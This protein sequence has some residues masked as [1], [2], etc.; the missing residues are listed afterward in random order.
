MPPDDKPNAPMTPREYVEQLVLPTLHEFLCARDDRRRAYLACLVVCHVA[1]SLGL[2]EAAREPG[3]AELSTSARK[4][5]TDAATKTAQ[6]VALERCGSTFTLVQDMANGT[7]H[8]ARLPLLP[9]CEV[10]VPPF[11]FGIAGPGF[12]L[13]RIGTPGLAVRIDDKRALLDACVQQVLA[14]FMCAYPQHLGGIA[15]AF[16]DPGL[17]VLGLDMRLEW[18]LNI[19][20]WA[21]GRIELAEV[22]L[23]GSRADGTSHPD[24]DVDLGVVLAA[25]NA[26]EPGAPCR[27]WAHESWLASQ[28]V[29]LGQLRPGVGGRLRVE[30]FSRPDEPR[31]GAE[32]AA[33]S[34]AILLWTRAYMTDA[35]LTSLSTR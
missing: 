31:G 11:S 26:S 23:F 16:M 8:P 19:S 15:L 3:F 33:R 20:T 14:A 1:D 25:P 30:V 35:K 13:G 28:G 32:A 34:S 21:G 5:K 12:G 24:S 6:S 10:R 22:W 17:P 2:A 27:D 18:L 29:W 4:R 7:K 9:G